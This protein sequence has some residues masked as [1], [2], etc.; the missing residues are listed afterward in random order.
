M[1]L[2]IAPLHLAARDPDTVN[3]QRRTFID[4]LRGLLSAESELPGLKAGFEELEKTLPP[5]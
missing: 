1:K 5:E 2:S 4:A 3:W